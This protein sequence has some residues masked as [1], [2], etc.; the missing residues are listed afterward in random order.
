LLYDPSVIQVEKYMAENG[1]DIKGYDMV[2]SDASLLASGKL[3][4]SAGR[5]SLDGDKDINGTANSK[6]WIDS[7]SCCLAIY[8]KLSS[9]Q[10]LMQQSPIALPKAV[11]VNFIATV[12]FLY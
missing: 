8:S 2:A 7:T 12:L 10:V 9:H 4:G 11:K 3:K 5:D 6:F 1:I